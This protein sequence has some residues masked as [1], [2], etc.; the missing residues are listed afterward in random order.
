MA[1]PGTAGA[2]SPPVAARRRRAADRRGGP[3]LALTAGIAQGRDEIAQV[4][5]AFDTVNRA[6][7]RLAGQQAE[8]RVDMTRMAEALARRIRTLITRQ[9]RLLDEF[10]RDETDPDALARLFALDHLAARLRRNGE[11]LLV[12]AGGEPGTR[13][14][15][16]AS[17]RR[18]GRPRA[19]EIEDYTRVESDLPHVA[20][21]GR[22]RRQPG[23]PAGRAAGER[24]R[25]LAA[26]RAGAG[27]TAGARSTALLLRVHDQGIGIG[28]S[29]LAEINERLAHAGHA[30]QRRGRAHGPARGGAPG[31]P[32]R[33]PGGAAVDRRG[34]HRL[35]GGA[36]RGARP[37]GFDP[38]GGRTRDIVRPV[39]TPPAALAAAGRWAVTSGHSPA[40]AG[41]PA[42]PTSV[43]GATAPAVA[44]QRP[45]CPGAT[46]ASSSHPS[47][48]RPPRPASIRSTRSWYAAG[49]PR[50]P[51]VSPP[52]YA[53]STAEP[54]GEI[55]ESA[56]ARPSGLAAHQLRRPGAGRR[57][58][59]GAS[60]ATGCG[61]PLRPDLSHDQ[62]DQLSAV[63]SGLASLTIGAARLMRAGRVRQQ[64]VDM[65]GGVMLVMSVGDRALLGVLAAPGCDLG[66]IGYETA[67]LVQR[68]AEALEPAARR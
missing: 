47:R 24:H 42:W 58:R 54:T 17:A 34:R 44:A 38:P 26:A 46:A 7:L 16:R 3:A 9:L 31:R 50:S 14:A 15:R 10:E 30:L 55:N 56:V 2:A 8:L 5:E 62:V 60:P 57:A 68:V 53:G 23:A 65:D 66:Q 33:H 48:R 37:A 19:A 61:S 35:R 41:L 45:G 27:A 20:V 18:R 11:N 12:L 63:I 25:L 1:A 51:Q 43:R 59:P 36:R 22:G 40:V 4:A 29:R 6:A 21:S 49:S 32:Q 67:M 52:R 28:A 13:A 64:I 39:G